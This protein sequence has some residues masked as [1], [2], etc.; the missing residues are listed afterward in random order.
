MNKKLL[1]KKIGRDVKN[2]FDLVNNTSEFIPG[3]SKIK[4]IEPTFNHEEIIEALDSMISTKVTMGHKVRLFEKSFSRYCKSKYAT[5]VNSG[6]SA[7]LLAVSIF[8]NPEYSKKIKKGSEVLTP[9][10]TWAT[11]IFPLINVGLKPKLIDVDIETFCIDSEQIFDAVDE[12][13]GLILPVHLLGNVC[14]MD[15]ITE[16][17][18][19]KDIL[20]MEDCCEAHGAK[21]RNKNVGTFGQLGTFSFFMSHHITTMEGGMVITNDEN[22]DELSKMLRAFGWTRDIKR[23]EERNKDY[24]DIDPRFLF[25]NIGFNIR[26]TEIQGGFGIKQISKLDK[27]IKIRRE[28][29]LYWNKALKQYEEY[30][31]LPKMQKNSRQVHFCYP[32]TIKPDAPFTRFEIFNFLERKKI[33]TRPIMAGNMAEQPV[34]NL[35]NYSKKGSLPNSKLIMKNSFFI[36]NHQGIGKEERNYVADVISQFIERKVWKK[37]K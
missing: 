4:L 9:A 27:F 28:N 30:F 23:R 26:P 18:E 1:E 5:M 6:S 11:T 16:I 24:P 31:I 37:Y 7:N 21:F 3:K 10:V 15:K 35:I 13:T 12:K 8:T 32:L 2:L 19:K 25:V 36:G 14:E 17:V 34:M 20:L 22:V 33:E 29:H